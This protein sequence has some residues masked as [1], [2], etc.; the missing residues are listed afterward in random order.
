MTNS[1]EEHVRQQWP[2]RP[3]TPDF[4]RLREV[5]DLIEKLKSE[6]PASAADIKKVYDRFIDAISVSYMGANRMG[7]NLPWDKGFTDEQM[8]DI[9]LLM[10][11]AWVEGVFFGV[12]FQILGGHRG[13][14]ETT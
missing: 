9:H 8:K 10:T 5:V 6:G 3:D 4:E 1:F 12:Y 7:M 14:D 13:T 11:D 2:F